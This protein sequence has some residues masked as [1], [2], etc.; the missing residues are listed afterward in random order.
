MESE[1]VDPS[2]CLVYLQ[3]RTEVGHK[4][5]IWLN[6]QHIVRHKSKTKGRA[7]NVRTFLAV[8]CDKGRQ[9]ESLS[10]QMPSGLWVVNHKTLRVV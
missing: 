2:H 7:V 6:D 5:Y 4:M 3:V 10:R 1:P 9:V 8:A